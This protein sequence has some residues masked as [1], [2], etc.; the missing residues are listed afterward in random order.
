MRMALTRYPL[1]RNPI[2][3]T[4]DYFMPLIDGHPYSV[5]VGGTFNGSSI[6][7]VVSDNVTG[8]ITLDGYGAVTSAAVF[9]FIAPCNELIVRVNGAPTSVGVIVT[10]L[11]P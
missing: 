8:D 7:F 4:G 3:T 1:T 2:T 5:M 11:N 9:A 10:H 6:N